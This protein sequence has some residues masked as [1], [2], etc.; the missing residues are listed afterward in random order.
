MNP[1]YNTI[2]SRRCS[3]AAVSNS[4]AADAAASR[5]PTTEAS[6]ATT[7][8]IRTNR[9][10]AKSARMGV[11]VPNSVSAVDAVQVAHNGPGVIFMLKTKNA[12]VGDSA[13]ANAV[14]D[15]GR[16]AAGRCSVP[17]VPPSSRAASTAISDAHVRPTGISSPRRR[18]CSRR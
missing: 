14:S 8:T 18:S 1:R 9:A 13:M 10:G 15:T 4:A 16:S 6:V 7:R 12:T 17:M 11:D 5:P 2:A 3:A